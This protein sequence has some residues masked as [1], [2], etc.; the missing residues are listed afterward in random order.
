MALIME[1][2]N[3]ESKIIDT[4]WQIINI[5]ASW[6]EFHMAIR[7]DLYFII[8]ILYLIRILK[9]KVLGFL[10]WGGTVIHC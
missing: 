6:L 5:T 2:F 4:Y 7:W 9:S 10:W 1:S 8:I 3:E